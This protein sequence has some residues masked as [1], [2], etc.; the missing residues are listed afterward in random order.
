MVRPDADR[1]YGQEMSSYIPKPDPVRDRFQ[2]LLI[3]SLRGETSERDEPTPG[4]ARPGL[5]VPELDSA[6]TLRALARAVD[7]NVR[8]A[9]EL[10]SAASIPTRLVV[11][12]RERS[13]LGTEIAEPL[14]HAADLIEAGGALD[15]PAR[16]IIELTLGVLARIPRPCV[17]GRCRPGR[18]RQTAP[19]Y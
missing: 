6:S 14:L 4:S 11:A 16:S 18:L 8:G 5:E 1:G 10:D 13:R 17:C 9:E 15:E 12:L 7:P 3:S 2:Q 19:A